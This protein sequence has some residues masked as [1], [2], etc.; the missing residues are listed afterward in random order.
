MT[1]SGAEK[2]SVLRA[3]LPLSVKLVITAKVVVAV[4]Y[5]SVVLRRLHRFLAGV[6][7][8]QKYP[9]VV[10]L[11]RTMIALAV[12]ASASVF[13]SL[14][15][16]TVLQLPFDSDTIGTLFIGASIYQISVLLIRHPLSR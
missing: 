15:P 8:P 10:W 3:G 13:I 16:R 4:A 9:H 11:H 14:L 2:L 6:D 1:L 7:D 5:L 12:M